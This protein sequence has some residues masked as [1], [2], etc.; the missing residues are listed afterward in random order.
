M[1]IKSS[2]VRDVLE[3]CAGRPASTVLKGLRGSNVPWLPGDIASSLEGLSMND[4]FFFFG[5][6]RL[7]GKDILLLLLPPV[8]SQALSAKYLPVK[9]QYSR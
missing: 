8:P 7:S 5:S 4:L 3:P 2:V 6:F 9:R 1:S